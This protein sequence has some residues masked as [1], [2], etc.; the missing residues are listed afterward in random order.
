MP[1]LS[2]IIPFRDR[3]PERVQRCL[4]SIA[5]QDFEDYEVILADYGSQTETSLAVKEVCDVFPKVRYVYNHTRGWLWNP[6]HARNTALRLAQGEFCLTI[7]VD[8][9]YSAHFLPELV[10]KLEKNKLVHYKCYYL[11]ESFKDYD[12][13][14]T[15]KS[16]P[17]RASSHVGTGLFAAPMEAVRSI[18][19][20]DE[21]YRMW[22]LED[23][24][25]HRRLE[26][27]GLEVEWMN[28]ETHPTFH[29]WHVKLDQKE[30]FPQGWFEVSRTYYDRQA[31]KSALNQA[32][33][34]SL[35]VPEKRP[36]LSEDFHAK[37]AF[38]FEFPSRNAQNQ[39]IAQFLAL[40]PGENIEI[41]QRFEEIQGEGRTKL[42]DFLIR[43]NQWL[44]KRKIS[45]RIVEQLAYEQ[46]Q[47]GYYG[48]RDFLCFFILHFED[49][50]QDY[51]FTFKNHHIHFRAVRA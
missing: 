28:I 44:A 16:F 43:I 45:Y 2:L 14:N 30:T 19:G 42:G 38:R 7:D 32:N 48:L 9:I 49:Y 25:F 12:S 40:E 5:Q 8:L 29:Q 39:L 47:L 22:G 18:S 36:A 20:F 41:K 35:I 17:F 10:K 6:S 11:P 3:E 21:F 15:L 50:M 1:L 33:W 37:I 13:L 4:A 31:K 23:M 34:G 27:H 51:Y 46:E 24:D 26:N